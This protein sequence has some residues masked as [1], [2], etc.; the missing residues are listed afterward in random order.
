MMLSRNQTTMNASLV[1]MPCSFVKAAGVLAKMFL[2]LP[3]SCVQFEVMVVDSVRLMKGS[4]TRQPW[5]GEARATIKG[6]LLC[7]GTVHIWAGH[8]LLLSED[9]R[10]ICAYIEM[11][12]DLGSISN[13]TRLVNLM[14]GFEY[15][16]PPNGSHNLMRG[17]LLRVTGNLMRGS[18]NRFDLSFAI[19]APA[20]TA[21]AATAPAATARAP[22]A[23]AP[24]EDAEVGEQKCAICMTNKVTMAAYPC[25]HF[26]F[27]NG[28]LSQPTVEKCPI[29]RE[30]ITERVRIFHD[31]IL[32]EKENR[33]EQIAKS[34]P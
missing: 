11:G 32:K 2:A 24:D 4:F 25:M 8:S 30:T 1:N 9:V 23:T 20:A 7:N 33:Q 15:P 16:N 12:Q 34:I 6:A 3:L 14:R 13:G 22:V 21:P 26:S 10:A 18:R 29:C 28:C 19:I 17:N 27:C 5:N 31:G